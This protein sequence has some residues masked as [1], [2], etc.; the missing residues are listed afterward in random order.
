MA[1][2]LIRRLRAAPVITA[3]I[4]LAA[5]ALAQPTVVN[6]TGNP[7]VDIPA[8]QAAVNL[9]GEVVL[10]GHFS[11]DKPPTIPSPLQAVG[12]PQAMVLISKTV[13]I[14]GAGDAIIERGTIPFYVAAPGAS[15]SIQ[16]LRF[17]SPSKSAIVVYAVSGL[18]VA[19]CRI[20]G[21][22]PL[23][24]IQFSGIGIT[25]SDMAA[26]PT[27]AQPGHP[28]NISGRIVI[29]NNDLDLVGGTPSDAVLGITTF[30]AG[31]LP[32]GEVD[33][34][35]SGNT[36]NNVNRP[37]IDIRRLGGRAHVEGN[38][39][40]T[41]PVATQATPESIRVVGIGSFVIAHNVIDCQWS[42]PD[43]IG[44]GA[45]SQFADWP[46]T[47]VVIVD[48]D[49]TM[50][51]PGGV[52]FTSFSAGIDIRGFAQGV[53]VGD[54][55][56]LGRA[57]AAVAV[58]VFSGG[59]PA[60]TAFVLNRLE[61]FDASVAQ[62]IVGSGVTG[63][64]I[65]GPESSVNDQG[66]NTVIFP[67]AGRMCI[68]EGIFTTAG[69]TTVPRHGHTATL[70]TDGRVLIAGGSVNPNGSSVS[71]AELYT[72][73]TGT[74]SSTGSMITNR[75]FHTATLLLDGK[76]LIAGGT[77]SGNS[78]LASAEL[79]DTATGTFT[80]TGTMAKARSGHLAALLPNG[81]VLIAGGVDSANCNACPAFLVGSELY[82]PVAGTFSPT[83]DMHMPS[84]ERNMA[85]LLASGKVFIGGGQSSDLYDTANGTFS[86]TGGWSTISSDWPDAQ[87]LLTNG[88]VLVT[89]G[90][91]DGFGSST[92][93]GVYDPGTGRF[94]LTG[95]MSA[96]RDWH[97]ATTLPDGT[98]LITG[99]QINGGQTVSA[100]EL[101]DPVIGGFVPA[102]SMITS[103]CCHTATLLNTGQV[104]IVG[105]IT[106]S[107]G[108]PSYQPVNVITA[109]LYTPSVMIPAPALFSLSSDGKG[110]G[111]I[112]D[113][114]TGK[115]AS[116]SAPAVAG[117][118][119]SMY[120]KGLGHGSVIP[121][122]VAVGGRLS[123][124][125]YFG[126]APGYPGYS[127][128]NFRVPD[129]I[130][131]GSAVRVRLIYLG[132]SSNE[133]TIAMN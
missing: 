122:Q 91:P 71:S 131:P 66:I 98:A 127:Q 47:N 6:G 54:N 46:I 1:Q 39:I 94:R 129:G 49:I 5:S 15:V 113:A 96:A 99:G 11:F 92:F 86:T 70:L 100:A 105:G 20:E 23:P 25:A 77:A 125:L 33:L 57:R 116:P 107:Q 59:V 2:Q 48:N 72:P 93:A 121:P 18:V 41:S 87:G 26:M 118:I 44:I 111:A 69:R 75:Q 62:I 22:V 14:S 109:E 45:Y 4:A 19:S 37:G 50:S 13:A 12:F 117:E 24:N 36:I 17:V 130:T 97:N 3:A 51:A 42:N 74:F 110:Q 60:D 58:D 103:R 120:T 9:G 126:D 61:G 43:A 32:T 56:I 35:I 90:N 104:L 30:S 73:A 38:K 108:Y 79:Y 123:E 27:P 82:D 34:Y 7:D 114:I 78:A 88:Q 124:I 112:W 85:I 89:G 80:T 133:V 119:L 29:A 102:G 53:F 16:K 52:R 28:E 21:F 106:S 67:C 8:V 64:L 76:V 10:G 84:F 101:Y 83:A 95:P 31:Q 63:T 132:R 68:A 65:L 128:V 81:K 40:T 115:V 55:Y